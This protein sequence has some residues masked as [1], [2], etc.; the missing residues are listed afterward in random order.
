MGT[1]IRHAGRRVTVPVGTLPVAMIEPA[2]R[3]PLVAA[4]GCAE[5][6]SPGLPAA[7]R[8]AIALAA[9]AVCTNPEQR[10]ASLAAT[11]SLPEKDF[12]MNRHPP[13]QAGFDNGNGSCHGRSSFDGGLL[14]KVAKP[15]PRCSNGGVLLPAFH[16][17]IQFFAGMF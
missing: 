14:M 15:E 6:L 2:L 11:N 5:L 12:S 10:L 7:G 4:V 17:T 9:V 16:A 8:A 3:T 1:L 13:T